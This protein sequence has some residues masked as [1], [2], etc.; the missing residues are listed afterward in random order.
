M[1]MEKKICV[2][3]SRFN[4]NLVTSLS[5]SV[6]PL[7]ITCLACKQAFVFGTAAYHTNDNC[8]Q[9]SY[10]NH[11]HYGFLDDNTHYEVLYN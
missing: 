3:Y 10:W 1:K 4:D 7:W 6:I 9:K 5:L 11:R 2:H 8:F